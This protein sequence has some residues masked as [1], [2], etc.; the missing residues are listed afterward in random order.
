MQN[1]GQYELIQ[2]IWLSPKRARHK[3]FPLRN[4]ADIRY[5]HSLRIGSGECPELFQRK[6]MAMVIK[7]H[8]QAGQTA[9]VGFTL[10][11][12]LD[13]TLHPLTQ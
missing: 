5:R 13:R 9:L 11:E 4:I 3:A 7:Y 1:C 8:G 10:V 6:P 12:D 2:F